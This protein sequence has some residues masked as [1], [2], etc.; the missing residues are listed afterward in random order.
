LSEIV[1]VGPDLNAAMAAAPDEKS[2]ATP[3]KD[4][5]Q[6]GGRVRMRFDSET[7]ETTF[8]QQP[9]DRPREYRFSPVQEAGGVT[10]MQDGSPT[11]LAQARKDALVDIPALGGQTSVA[12]AVTLGYLIPLPQGGY[13][14]ADGVAQ[15]QPKAS[16]QPK[17]EAAPKP[18]EKIDP[19][20]TVGLPSLPAET[21]K[22]IAQV[23]PQAFAAVVLG[24]ADGKNV[25]NLLDDVAR[26]IGG[27]NSREQAA[28]VIEQHEAVAVKAVQNVGVEPGSEQDF[29][30]DM[31]GTAAYQDAW[32]A[33]AEKHNVGPMQTLA[34]KWVQASNER[35]ATL[36]SA[37]GVDTRVE[38]GVVYVSRKALGLGP[39]PKRGDFGG[40]DWSPLR[41]MIREGHVEING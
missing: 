18:E 1:R 37:K 25:D 6:R 23:P 13:R 11:T 7:G 2:N 24:L 9:T 27:E 12:A 16:E 32:L 36:I 31:R 29:H 22:F 14:M 21:D 15:E 19:K 28:Q 38:D 40:G 41:Q 30:N 33:L 10:V 8:E 17:P 34:R 3:I 20:D 4:E 35:L 26:T 39:V 5:L